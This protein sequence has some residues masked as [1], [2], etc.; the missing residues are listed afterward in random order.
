MKEVTRRII[1]WTG[2]VFMTAFSAL[3]I[4]SFFNAD[5]LW[6]KIVYVALACLIVGLVLFAMI[7]FDN[8][9]RRAKQQAEDE[10]KAR[11]AENKRKREQ[12]QA[13]IAE[14]NAK[15]QSAEQP[16]G[17]TENAPQQES[18][19]AEQKASDDDKADK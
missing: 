1:A 7:Y 4:T 18:E 13:K 12:N 10:E 6:G 14:Q 8:K 17:V 3:M 2:L 15:E 5:L 19:P 16:D 11:R 9:E